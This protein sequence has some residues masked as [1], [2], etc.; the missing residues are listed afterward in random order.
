MVIFAAVLFAFTVYAA[1]QL[2]QYE[3]KHGRQDK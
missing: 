3:A 2:G 1:Y